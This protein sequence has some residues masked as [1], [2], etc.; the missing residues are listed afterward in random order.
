M[1]CFFKKLPCLK[2]GMFIWVGTFLKNFSEGGVV[3]LFGMVRLLIFDLCAWGY[4][5]LGW[6]VY[7]EV[8]S[9]AREVMGH[10]QGCVRAV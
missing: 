3:R 4:V 10:G 5:Y 9:N 7:L 1:V 2:G 6:Y 8:Y